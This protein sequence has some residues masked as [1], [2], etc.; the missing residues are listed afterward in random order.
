MRAIL[1]H[2]LAETRDH[3][4]VPITG[5]RATIS[6]NHCAE[7]MFSVVVLCPDIH[8]ACFI[9]LDAET[10]AIVVAP[11]AV[12]DATVQLSELPKT[13]AVVIEPESIIN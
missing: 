11:L 9:C 12:V 3:V 5:I 7:S 4:F 10:H 1:V 2:A 6:V 13:M 8:V